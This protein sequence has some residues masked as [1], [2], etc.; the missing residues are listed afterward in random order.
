MLV[1]VNSSFPSRCNAEQK[2]TITLVQG[3]DSTITRQYSYSYGNMNCYHANDTGRIAGVS[4]NRTRMNVRVIMPDGTSCIFIGRNLDQ[5]INGG[6]S[7]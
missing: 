5:T 6:Y 2:V 4:I 3:P 7:C 1:G